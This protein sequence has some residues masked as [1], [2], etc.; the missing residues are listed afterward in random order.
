MSSGPGSEKSH[1]EVMQAHC[2]EQNNNETKKQGGEVLPQRQHV[3]RGTREM[4]RSEIRL[5]HF[6]TSRLYTSGI[7]NQSLNAVVYNRWI[8]AWDLSWF[9]GF[10]Q[11][12]FVGSV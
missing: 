12:A 1:D 6:R 2:A 3:C 9:C 7:V 10:I 5:L 11:L 4:M 8:Q